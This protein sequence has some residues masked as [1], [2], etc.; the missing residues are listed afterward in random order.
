MYPLRVL[1]TLKSCKNIKI[2]KNP[3]YMWVLYA[4]DTREEVKL[5]IINLVLFLSMRYGK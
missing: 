1:S 4:A 5:L 3:S 2:A